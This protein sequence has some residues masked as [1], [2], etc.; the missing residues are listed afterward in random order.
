MKNRQL[1]AAGFVGERILKQLNQNI[2]TQ[3]AKQHFTQYWTGWANSP[4][5]IRS[6]ETEDELI[7]RSHIEF[8]KLHVE[9]A[10]KAAA[11][12][13]EITNKSKFSGDYNPVVDEDSILNA[14][15]L[16]NIK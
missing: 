9:A 16:D 8:A 14:Y 11:E 5:E 12:N 15:P 1:G 10:L 2:M 6:N 7:E 4:I 13:A 3:T